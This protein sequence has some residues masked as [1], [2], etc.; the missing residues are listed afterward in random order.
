MIFYMNLFM[1]I[2]ISWLP[3]VSIALLV[4]SAVCVKKMT[5][6]MQQFV[7]Q[8]AQREN[9]SRFIAELYLMWPKICLVK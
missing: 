7:F 1:Q 2:S 9:M 3:Y 6:L 8:I 5:L 4:Y